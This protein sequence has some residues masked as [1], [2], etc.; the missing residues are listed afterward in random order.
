M[1]LSTHLAASTGRA[2]SGDWASPEQVL[3]RPLSL[4]SDIFSFGVSQLCLCIN[5]VIC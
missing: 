4:A 1:L 3:G 5:D 2:F